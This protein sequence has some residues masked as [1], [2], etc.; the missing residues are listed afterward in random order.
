MCLLVQ[1]EVYDKEARKKCVVIKNK[2]WLI[3]LYQLPML[4]LSGLFF[5]FCVCHNYLP[6]TLSVTF[7]SELYIWHQKV[8]KKKKTLSF[9]FL[10]YVTLHSL[11]AVKWKRHLEQNELLECS[12]SLPSNLCL[13]ML[14]NYYQNYHFVYWDFPV[15]VLSHFEMTIVCEGWFGKGTCLW[16]YFKRKTSSCSLTMLS[17]TLI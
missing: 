2:S 4:A 13:N 16:M 1:A 5:M 3:R 10:S 15:I 6:I 8:V 12:H 9:M 7:I 14:I 17:V 11:Q